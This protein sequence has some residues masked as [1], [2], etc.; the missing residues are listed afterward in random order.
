MALP[1]KVLPGF[2]ASMY[3]QPLTNPTVLTLAQLSTLSN[4][5]AIAVSGNL[6]NIEAIPAFGQDDAVASFTVAGARQSDKI[7]SQSA[8]TSMTI[9]AAWNPSDAVINTL[10]RTDAYSGTVDRTYVVAATDGTNIIYYSFI[11][12]V[13][14]FQI[15]SAPGA[16]AKCTFTIQPRGNL[17]GWV[18]N[19]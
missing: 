3:A 18:N 19:A 9:T 5:A 11:G 12:R 4:V 13:S 1:N 16:E 14:Q 6:M 7:P 15:D 17:Y 10:L 2:S 8:P